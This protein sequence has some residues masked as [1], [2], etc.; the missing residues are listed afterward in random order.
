MSFTIHTVGSAP[1]GAREVLAGAEQAYGFV[2]NLLGAMAEA[3]ALLEAYVTLSRLFEQSSLNATERQVVLLAVS[4]E[5]ACGYCVAAH[6]V[7]AG[8]Q[9]IP[10]EVVD[11]IR[12]GAP[13]PDPKLQ[14]LR[15]FTAAVVSSR[16]WPSEADLSA[17]LAAGYARQQVLEVVLG[18][19]L[20]TLS[21]YTNHIATPSLD[22]AFEPAAWSKVA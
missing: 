6:T 2:P 19:G 3:P 15:Q 9:R 20:K 12:R 10:G 1:D 22:R 11:A 21:N 14:A 13:L 16:G 18:V 17:L 4:V 7:I 8:M 5:N